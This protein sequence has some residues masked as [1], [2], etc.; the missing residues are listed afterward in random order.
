[1]LMPKPKSKT[2]WQKYATNRNFFILFLVIFIVSVVGLVIENNRQA[3]NKEKAQFMQAKTDLH[4][5]YQEIVAKV[6]EPTEHKSVQ[7]CEYSSSEFTKGSLSCETGERIRYETGD[8][9]S[10]VSKMK[11]LKDVIEDSNYISSFHSRSPTS[12]DTEGSLS[13]TSFNL[14]GFPNCGADFSSSKLAN[15]GVTLGINLYCYG[16]AKAE[17]FPVAEN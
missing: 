12:Y 8:K 6:G 10:A 16:N 15:D 13:F 7:S 4:S 1:M 17:Y 14:R 2:S 11:N 9:T 5:L 3:V